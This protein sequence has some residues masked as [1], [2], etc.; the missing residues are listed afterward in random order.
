MH[1][2]TQNIKCLVREYVIFGDPPPLMYKFCGLHNFIQAG[3]T[4]VTVNIT[5]GV[6]LSQDKIPTQLA[7]DASMTADIVQIVFNP[8]SVTTNKKT[9]ERNLTPSSKDAACILL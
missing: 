4:I 7:Q 3:L 6:S 2:F 8:F 5:N 1:Y 9:Y